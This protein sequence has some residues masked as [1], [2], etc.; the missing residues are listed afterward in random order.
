MKVKS[1][2]EA[3]IV[4]PISA[5]SKVALPLTHNNYIREG[6]SIKITRKG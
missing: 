2:R 6:W 3:R 5:A 1:K 4:R